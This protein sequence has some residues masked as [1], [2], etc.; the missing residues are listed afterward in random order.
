M[1]QRRQ[2]KEMSAL[3]YKINAR[4]ALTGRAH[5]SLANGLG[6]EVKERPDLKRSSAPANYSLAHLCK[7]RFASEEYR[8]LESQMHVRVTVH[9]HRSVLLHS[10]HS[11]PYS[12][13]HGC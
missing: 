13:A 12:G 9:C 6:S 3:Q 7:L 1:Q 10:L 2:S 8:V 4:N 11:E 5:V